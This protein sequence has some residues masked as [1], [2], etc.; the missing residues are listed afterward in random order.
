MDALPSLSLTA[1]ESNNAKA[2]RTDDSGVS[3]FAPTTGKTSILETILD[4]VTAE[5]GKIQNNGAVAVSAY[6]VKSKDPLTN[7]VNGL[8]PVGATRLELVTSS[9]SSWRSNQLS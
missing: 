3:Q 8:P 7:A 4:N 5:R 1:S 9:L 2:T 6:L